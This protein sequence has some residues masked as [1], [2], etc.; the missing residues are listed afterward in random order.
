MMCLQS[1]RWQGSS[2][3]FQ[4]PSMTFPKSTL[5]PPPFSAA[6]S[7]K[8]FSC[9]FLPR[10]SWS[11]AFLF[12]LASMVGLRLTRS[13]ILKSTYFQ[14]LKKKRSLFRRKKDAC[15]DL[16]GSFC[17]VAR[18]S[19]MPRRMDRQLASNP[20]LDVSFSFPIALVFALYPFLPHNFLL[21]RTYACLPCTSI[22]RR[23]LLRIVS[24]SLL[25]LTPLPVWSFRFAFLH[26]CKLLLPESIGHMQIDHL[27]IFWNPGSLI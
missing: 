21:A 23:P 15:K 6:V 27:F 24:H 9:H 8:W 7:T 25:V 12:S 1:M 11:Q 5:H 2:T 22:P 13:L 20:A 10:V 4:W 17:A 3:G 19:Q 26:F 18:D 16:Q 14:I